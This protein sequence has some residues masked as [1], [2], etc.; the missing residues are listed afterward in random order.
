FDGD[1]MNMHFPQNE[2]ARAEAMI[3]GNT[4]K[5]YLGPTS[6][7]PLRGLI[8]DHVVTG[9]WMTCKD[10]FFIKGDYQQI[11]FA[12]LRPDYLDGRKVLTVPPAIHKPKPLWTGKQIITS[13]LINLTRG[14]APLNLKSK[15]KISAKYW[16][17]SA[18]EEDT[19]IF[20]DGEH[21]TGVL[22]KS[23]I[24]NTSFGLVHSCYELYSADIAG[25]FLSTLGR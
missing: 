20:M 18:S 21:L 4:N 1:E 19:V 24:G 25:Q 12:A 23:Q 3:I 14:R 9:V 22:D 17:W 8:Q 10:T 11:V 7:N 6:G 2:I 16:G 13:V 15:N 5:Q